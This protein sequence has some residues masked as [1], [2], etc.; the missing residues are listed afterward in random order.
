M[1]KSLARIDNEIFQTIWNRAKETKSSITKRAIYLRIE[2]VR[3][4]FKK[5]ISLRMAANILAAEMD[6]D[7]YK[8]LKDKEE[9]KELRDLLRATPPQVITE[10]RKEKKR[11]KEKPIII[12]K[13]IV[14][15]FGL[16]RHLGK[17]AER[18]AEVYPAIYVFENTVR[19]VVMT[20]LE[21]KYGKNWWNEPN[22]VSKTIKRNVEG[23]KHKE[24]KNRWHSKRGSHEIF[25]TNFGNLSA[26]ISTNHNEFKEVFG[27][28]QIEAEMKQLELSRNI[29][30]HNNP[31]PLR[32][33]KRIKMY[34]EDLQRQL[35]IY[36]KKIE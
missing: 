34:S 23:R 5:S 22:V 16:P 21:K 29:I 8:L 2:A 3:K 35:N 13:K 36:T 31:L 11:E 28:L 14:E 26:I 6:I 27:E 17:E 12:G 10:T 19:H 1:A 7:V 32:E 30:A 33:V 18:M 9:L 20:V 25:Y 4:R 24:G 15:T